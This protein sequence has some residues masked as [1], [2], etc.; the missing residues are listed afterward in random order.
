MSLTTGIPGLLEDPSF[1]ASRRM[2]RNGIWYKMRKRPPTTAPSSKPNPLVGGAASVDP[3]DMITSIEKGKM[4][5]TEEVDKSMQALPN[6]KVAPGLRADGKVAVDPSNY[7]N[8]AFRDLLHNDLNDKTQIVGEQNAQGATR[9]NVDDHYS[10][11][12]SAVGPKTK[13]LVYRPSAHASSANADGTGSDWEDEV[14]GRLAEIN[15]AGFRQRTGAAEPS[16][17]GYRESLVD[18]VKLNIGVMTAVKVSLRDLSPD[19]RFNMSGSN[20]GLDLYSGE[21]DPWESSYLGNSAKSPIL[22]DFPKR[23]SAAN[24]A[25]TRS[26]DTDDVHHDPHR[27]PHAHHPHRHASPSDDSFPSS[28]IHAFISSAAAAAASPTSAAAPAAH[29]S[30]GSPLEEDDDEPAFLGRFASALPSS[31]SA[32][33]GVTTGS[34]APPPARHQHQHQRQ[35]RAARNLSPTFSSFP[36]PTHR[37]HQRGASGSGDTAGAGAAVGSTASSP[38]SYLSRAFQ[39]VAGLFGRNPARRRRGTSGGSADGVDGARVSLLDDDALEEEAETG[40]AIAAG[41]YTGANL[42]AGGSRT[43]GAAVGSRRREAMLREP[44]EFG[45]YD[46]DAPVLV[47][48][49][50]GQSIIVSILSL[51]CL[52]IL[53]IWVFDYNIVMLERIHKYTSVMA[54]RC[55]GATNGELIANLRRSGLI[56]TDAVEAAMLKVDRAKYAP[57]DCDDPYRDSP[58]PIGHHATCSAPHMHAMCLEILHTHLRPGSRVLDV[59][60]GSGYLTAAMAHLVRGPSSDGGTR[61]KVWGVEHVPELVE[62]SRA[63]VRRDPGSR[64]LMDEGTL[65]FVVGDGRKGL[66]ETREGFDAIHV[67]AAAPE[68]PHDLLAQLKE[69]GR[70]VIPVGTQSQDLRV[71]DKTKE[72]VKQSVACGVIYVPLTDLAS[73]RNPSLRMR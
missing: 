24:A 17:F 61:G 18:G 23:L 39:S 68:V 28:P 44:S 26:L 72:G 53:L 14:R 2:T 60:S 27:D 54:W 21:E 15:G 55:S 5:S 1:T 42:G 58:F 52:L 37:G 40:A 6:T 57:R 66:E 51:F 31:S 32:N 41:R 46:G 64:E 70:M 25:A 49:W 63:N 62:F 3:M 13:S 19:A 7:P 59:G 9:R 45:Q 16:L 36:G 35:Q 43:M 38:T 65:E 11:A 34:R 69:G 73:Q 10:R 22:F 20:S 67:G 56:K 48:S 12:T 47:P 29:G 33:A 8:Q 71:I 50:L 30:P 4:P